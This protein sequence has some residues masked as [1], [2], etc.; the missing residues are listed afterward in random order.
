[1]AKQKTILYLSPE[2]AWAVRDYQRRHRER[3][4]SVSAAVDHLLQ[5]ALASPV[6]A[7]LDDLLAPMIARGVRDAAAGAV[8]GQLVPLLA[9]Q[10]DRLAGIL[11]RVDR[12][13]IA[14]G[15]DAAIA[16]ALIESVVAHLLGERAH[17]IAAD[18]RLHAG[19][20]YAR[21]ASGDGG[22]R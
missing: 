17:E 6:D 22:E 20:K 16:A 11:V 12:D 5:R 21:R 2:L 3:F 18:A 1:M 7:G 8:E 9:A 15:K 14:T 19:A 13:C 4:R 10:T